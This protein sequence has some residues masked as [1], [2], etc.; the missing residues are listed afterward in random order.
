MKHIVLIASLIFL[1]ASCGAPKVRLSSKG[2]KVEVLKR[3]PDSGDCSVI[4]KVVGENEEG[5]ADLAQ[6]HA[7]NLVGNKGGN[8][9]TFD[10]EVNNGSH[11]KIY[12]TGYKCK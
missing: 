12:S 1:A 7:R 11:F 10:E 8:A 4:G 3:K 6:N 5:S 2:E 9:I